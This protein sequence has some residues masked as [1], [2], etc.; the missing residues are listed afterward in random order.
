MTDEIKLPD[1]EYNFKYTLHYILMGLIFFFQYFSKSKEIRADLNSEQKK[2]ADKIFWKYV[3]VYQVA[4]AA[5]WCL[6]PFT[7]EFFEQYH[8]FTISSIAKM[9]AVSFFSNMVFGPFL[10]GYINDKFDKK[11]PCAFYGFVL[12]IS[13]LIKQVKHPFAIIFSQLL[14]GASTSI[15]YSSFENWFI[16]KINEEVSDQAVRESI[17]SNGFEKSM[18]G[19]SLTAVSV[20]FIAGS[21]KVNNNN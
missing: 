18:I 5:D 16:C 13:C 8:G 1:V 17:L 6:G 9:Q 19:D 14:F 20:S 10:I 15:L 7:Y 4:K 12:G 2:K 21:L 3:I 11:F